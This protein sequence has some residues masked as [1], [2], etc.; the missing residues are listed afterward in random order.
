MCDKLSASTY[1]LHRYNTLL[2]MNSNSSCSFDDSSGDGCDNVTTEGGRCVLPPPSL[3]V[4]ASIDYAQGMFT[5]A[6][7]AASL[8]V[9][10]SVICLI[11]RYKK[12]RNK[13]TFLAFQL[14]TINLIQTLVVLPAI[15]VSSFARR[16]VFGDVLC[17][18]SGGFNALFFSVHLVLVL[19]LALDQTFAVCL[20]FFY[21]RHAHKIVPSMS[22]GVWLTGC[23]R[24]IT[25]V[26]MGC[27]TYIP[28]HKVCLASGGCGP[29]CR[30]VVPLFAWTVSFMGIV[31]PIV[32]F[33]ALYL[34]G[35]QLDQQVM[36]AEE[37]SKKLLD[38]KVFNM[39]LMLLLVLVCVI[40]PAFAV[41]AWFLFSSKLT[42]GYYVV[43]S[44][45][46]RTLANGITVADSVVIMRYIYVLIKY[47]TEDTFN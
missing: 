33:M 46:G 47:D 35:R 28:T 22:L 2:V 21:S 26:S 45:V 15:V 29:A 41:Y 16:W 10:I 13:A 25:V 7:I 36:R 17:T 40:L 4:P 42:L 24:A 8:I 38:R 20:P 23:L 5:L 34:R 12:L 43:Q 14:T 37:S 3:H 31:V 30:V 19:V 27:V 1:L 32:L 6:I 9:N 11:V 18:F 39:Y 44:L